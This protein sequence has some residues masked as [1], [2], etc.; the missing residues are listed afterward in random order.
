MRA[1]TTLLELCIVLLIAGLI[2]AFA[3][4]GIGALHDHLAVDAAAQALVS[5]HTRA[6]AAA[7]GEF[8]NMVLTLTADSL[9]LRAV[10]SPAD[11]VERWR[12]PGPSA[13]GVASTGMPHL[14]AFAPSGV[15]MGF[16]NAT[17]ALARGGALRQV[18]VSRYGRVRVQ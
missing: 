9:V 14:V 17:Y 2:A 7:Q 6:R 10:E 18:I 15:T 8:R 11:T 1:G 13:E 16:A 12:G 3:L 4:P 5:A